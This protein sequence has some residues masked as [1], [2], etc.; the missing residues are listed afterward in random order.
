M[1]KNL[2]ASSN[3]SINS[4]PQKIWNVLTNPKKVKIYLYGTKIKTDWKIGSPISFEG[5]YQGKKYQDKGI[6]IDNQ[7]L[8]TI[9][10]SYW[11]SFS[12]LEDKTENYSIICYKLKK[13][14]EGIYIFTWHQ[15]GFVSEDGK[16]HT[17]QGLIEML[18]EIKRLAEE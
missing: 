3:I 10:Y 14:G 2:I 11:S 1:N 16:C 8:Q 5:E 6:I 18:K 12:G 13:Q 17:K 4:T 7:P 9:T 15:Q